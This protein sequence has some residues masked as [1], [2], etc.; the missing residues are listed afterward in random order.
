MSSAMK[1]FFWDWKEKKLKAPNEFQAET[2]HDMQTAIIE[3]E[4]SDSDEECIRG[5]LELDPYKI[6]M[7]DT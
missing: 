2:L 5:T 4:D 1:Q 6:F 3:K 7:S